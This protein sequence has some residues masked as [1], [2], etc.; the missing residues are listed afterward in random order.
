MP[1]RETFIVCFAALTACSSAAAQA[2]A[3]PRADLDFFE[4]KVRPLLSDRCF[5][6]HSTQAK[7]TRGG[8]NL[9]SRTS[10]LKGGDTGPAALAGNPA[11][12][13]LLR[14]VRYE[15]GEL[16]MPPQGKLPDHEI[17][18][19]TE[20]VRRGL[21]YPDARPGQVARTTID[22]E[23]GRGFWSF[24]TFKSVPPPVV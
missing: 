7:K 21:P 15:D 10:I 14:A 13:L 4:S 22:I 11:K 16:A 19:L 1:F 9:D 6:C 23:Q 18:M 17:A 20:W 2:P 24:Q 12:S 5:S 3:F 8:L